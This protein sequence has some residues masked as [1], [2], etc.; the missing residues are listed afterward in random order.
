MSAIGPLKVSLFRFLDTSD[1]FMS[2]STQK[3]ILVLE[4]DRH[5]LSFVDLVLRCRHSKFMIKVITERKK[6]NPPSAFGTVNKSLPHKLAHDIVLLQD[7]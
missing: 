2:E 3:L 1:V 6:A 7:E 5:K 4:L